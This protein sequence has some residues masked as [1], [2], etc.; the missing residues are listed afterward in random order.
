MKSILI[1]KRE[2]E[3]EY[4]FKVT[5]AIIEHPEHPHGRRF[6]CNGFGGVGELRGGAVRWEHGYA[7]KLRSS[8][9]FAVLDKDDTLY[10]ARHGYGE[11]RE[12][13]QWDWFLIEKIAR[14][15]GL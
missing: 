7:I 14:S 9:T 13:M 1:E 11:D 6:I 12:I 2:T 3:G 8:D 4:G 15:L 10:N 5:E